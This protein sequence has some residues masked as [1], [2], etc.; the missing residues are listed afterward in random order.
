MEQRIKD[1]FEMLDRNLH[2]VQNSIIKH[3]EARMVEG[4]VI[5]SVADGV[6]FVHQMKA[7]KLAHA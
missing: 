7:R 2:E 4:A 1:P 3:V 6:V 5:T